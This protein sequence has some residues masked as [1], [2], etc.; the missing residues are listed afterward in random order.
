[1]ARGHTGR[2]R[3]VGFGAQFGR[4][5]GA[6]WAVA[7]CTG[8]PP[9]TDGGLLPVEGRCEFDL[10]SPARY[11]DFERLPGATSAQ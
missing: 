3:A 9:S 11:A 7:A 5:A 10:L 4:H 2:R 6:T 8:G 1:M